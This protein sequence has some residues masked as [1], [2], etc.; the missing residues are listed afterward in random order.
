MKTHTPFHSEQPK[1]NAVP[2]GE[3]RGASLFCTPG[4]PCPSHDSVPIGAVDTFARYFTEHFAEAMA[5]S[6]HAA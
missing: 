6:K 5:E 1:A 3:D 2:D 4:A